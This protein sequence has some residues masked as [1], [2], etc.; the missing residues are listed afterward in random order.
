MNRQ[1]EELVR[2]LLERFWASDWTVMDLFADDV[3]LVDPM[4]PQ[5]VEGKAEILKTFKYCHEWGELSPRI[6]NIFASGP[7]AAAEFIVAGRVRQPLDGYPPS[8]VGA[9][10]EFAEADTFEFNADGLVKRMS[11]YADVAGFD[12]QMRDSLLK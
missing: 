7:F 8:V 10:F 5:P 1:R 2:Q 3:I 6:T 11:I 12:R 9:Q 4:L